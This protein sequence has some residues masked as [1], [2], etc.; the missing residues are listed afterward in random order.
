GSKQQL[1]LMALTQPDSSPTTELERGLPEGVP[2]REQLARILLQLN[3]Y[4]GGL[5]SSSL[6]LKAARIEA[7]FPEPRPSTVRRLLAEW[8]AAAADAGALPVTDPKTTADVLI[9]TLESRHIHAYMQQL[10][11]STRQH[12]D[13]IRQ[14]IAVVL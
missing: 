12:R 5:I 8:L 1:I 2:P 3:D 7:D 14:M 4:L 13:Y 6:M 11:Y 9:G 10:H